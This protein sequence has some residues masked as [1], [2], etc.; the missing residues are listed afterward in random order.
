MNIHE[1]L[2]LIGLRMD[3]GKYYR[4]DLM[5]NSVIDWSG[6]DLETLPEKIWERPPDGCAWHWHRCVEC[7]R[8]IPCRVHPD[9]DFYC[10]EGRL[11]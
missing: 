9:A 7:D 11:A 10:A 4:W 5:Y 1:V 2:H 8:A 3:A 6:D